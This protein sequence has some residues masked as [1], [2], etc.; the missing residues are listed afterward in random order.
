[1]TSVLSIMLTLLTLEPRQAA[2]VGAHLAGQGHLTRELQGI[3]RRE[4][5]CNAIGIHEIDR[6]Y[7]PLMYKKAHL[8]NWLYSWC[9]FHRGDPERFGVRGSFGLSA[10][11]SLR[12]LP[13][14]WPPEVMDIPIVSAYLAAKRA[15]NQCKKY[16]ACTKKAHRKFW[17][18][19]FRKR[20]N[21]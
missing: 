21:G 17:A 4:S 5:R 19:G 12:F 2:R 7:G 20:N 9:P 13:G 6:E 3:C 8:V 15:E 16:G 14:C 18:G 1:M 10:A 11:Y